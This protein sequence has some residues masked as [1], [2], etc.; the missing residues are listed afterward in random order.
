MIIHFGVFRHLRQEIGA[1]G[2]VLLAAIGLDA[3]VLA[4]FAG[5][6]WQFDPLI[7]A[8]GIAGMALVFAFVGIFLARTPARDNAHDQH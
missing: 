1:K 2:W 7:V 3:V 6:K 8:F 5:M 4:A